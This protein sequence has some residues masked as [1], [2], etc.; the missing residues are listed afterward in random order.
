MIDGC[1]V[2]RRSRTLYIELMPLEH[3]HDRYLV[4]SIIY[5]R[6]GNSQTDQ[7]IHLSICR[8]QGLHGHTC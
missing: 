6:M 3:L 8:V 1:H 2:E 5:L 4:K 7:Q